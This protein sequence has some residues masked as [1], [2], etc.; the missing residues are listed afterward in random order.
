M[1]I[2]FVIPCLNSELII[3]KSV[4]KLTKKLKKIKKLN[5][6]LILIDDGSTDNTNKIINSLKKKN[7][8]LVKNAKNLGKSTSLIKGIKFAKFNKII[9]CDSD[10]PY[11]KYLSK[12]IFLLK[13]NHL[14]YINR[15]S[16]KS[17]LETRKL[18]LYQICRYF[19]GRIVCLIL[20]LLLLNKNTGDTQA[21]LKGFQKPK[22]F[23]KINFLSKKFFFDAELMILFHRSKAKMVS[24]P[25]KYKIY[26]DS[27]IKLFALQNFI[28]LIELFKIILFYK[29][30]L[31]KKI[32]F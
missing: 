17:S 26:S 14:V 23:K 12:L 25:L 20:N 16:P 10:L 5:Y 21:G 15:K 28:Y 13:N 27:T 3:K 7:I 11:F 31:P 2:S 29:F 19:I 24:I 9:L 30:K 32:T 8:R 4:Q 6:E 1:N 18:N 22:N